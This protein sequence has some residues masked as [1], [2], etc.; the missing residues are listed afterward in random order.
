MQLN[1]TRGNGTGGVIVLARQGSSVDANPVNG[2]NYTFNANYGSG[3]EVGTGN[4]VVYKGAA[5]NAVITGLTPG[6]LYHFAVYEY[7]TTTYCHTLPGLVGNATTTGI[8]PSFCDTLSQFCCTPSLY[9][10]T[11]SGVYAGYLS[12]TNGY[13]FE[14]FAEYFA[15][16]EPFNQV[17][18]M[19]VYLGEV[20]TTTGTANVTFALWDNENGVPT[21]ILASKVVT[22]ANVKTAF[23]N[24]GYID[25]NFDDIIN[26]PANGFYLGLLEPGNA[27]AG[28]T[29]AIVTNAEDEGLNSGYTIYGSWSPYLDLFGNSFQHAIYAFT[30]FDNSLPPIAGFVGSPRRVALGSTVQFTDA[31]AGTDPT[32]WEWS[33]EGGT[34]ATSTEANQ[35]VTYNSLGFFDASLTVSN[36]NGSNS[37]TRT[38]YIEVF[39]PNGTTAFSL[40]FEACSD[41]QVDQFSPWTTLDV[42]GKVTYGSTNFDYPNEGYTGS[43]IAFNSANTT[44]AATGWEAHGGNL[45]GICMAATTPPNNDWLMSTQIELGEN[46]SF[47]FWAKSITATYGLERFIVYVST[48]GNATANFVKISAGTYLEAPTTWTQYTYDLSAYDNMSVYVAIRCVSNDA[49]AFMLDDIEIYSEYVAPVCD[50]TADNTTVVEGSTVNFTDLSTQMPT[51]WQWSFPGGTPSS[52]T[53]QNPAIVYSTPGTYNVS[54]TVTNSAGTDSEVKTGYITVTP[55]PTVIVLWNFPNT[56]D[57]NIADAGITNNLTKTIVPFGGVNDVLYTAAGVSTRSIDGETWDTGNGTKG[58]SVNFTTLG[59]GTLKLSFAQMSNHANS[60]RDFKVQYSLNGTSWTD[61]GVN[62]T[63]VEDVW[64]VRNDIALPAACENKA[65]VYLRWIMTSNT[66]C[67][68]STVNST[69]TTRRNA[70]D[71]IKVTG[72]P[73]ATPPV[74]DFIASSTQICAGQSVTFSDLS[75]NTPTS[76]AWTF[77]GGS[78]ATSNLQSPTVSYATAGT[79]QV[80]LTATNGSGSDTE[81]KVGYITVNA[82]PTVSASNTGPYCVGNTISLNATGSGGTSYSWT[83]PASFSSTAEDPTRTNALTTHTGNY[84]VVL[85]NTVTGCTATASTSVTVN[86]NPTISASNTGPYCAGQTISL[87]ATGSAG[88]TFAWSGPNSYSSTTEDPS[89]SNA[90]SINAGTYTVVY[91]NTTTNCFASANT[92]VVVNANPTVSPTNGGPYCAGQTIALTANGSGGTSYAWTGPNSYAN[93][94]ANPSIP[95]GQAVNAGTYTLVLTNTGTG[96]T[97]TGTTTVTVNPQPTISASNN[98]PICAGATL[99]LFATGSGGTAYS[100]TGP[101]SFSTII[102]DP[103]RTNAL[104]TYSGNYTVVLTNTTTGCTASATTSATVNANPTISASNNGPICAGATLNLFAAGSGGTGYSWTGPA[105][106]NTTIEDP[107]RTNALSTYS[108]TYTVVLTNSTT[109]CT[110]SATTNATINDNPTISASNNGPICADQHLTCLRQAQE[111]RVTAG[112]DP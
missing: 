76:W 59:Y 38:D 17:W 111:E 44:P 108:G 95:N 41:F 69:N 93:A 84:N 42:D 47:S 56:T 39:D 18:G 91:T 11:S 73:I 78:P 48:T 19:R 8:V 65:N 112:Q 86:S 40:D 14:G 61:L 24:L 66:G 71:D 89:I 52:S 43:F 80:S 26:A 67:G 15:E 82:N 36:A 58:W 96:C 102:E 16:H 104:T 57:N 81:T 35:V 2:V 100:W 55:T 29:I 33:F 6:T 90:Q 97:A 10:V 92:I 20:T 13:G 32:S 106:F 22:M 68:G 74:A 70:M 77:A 34:P 23:D 27:A 7:A 85:T 83:G 72:L 28:D 103:S 101:V 25:I 1:W 12:G 4:Y 109:G 31:S 62:I 5:S 21:N 99:N 46:S 53:V 37:V 45:C 107:S 98:G 54:L 49:Y 88:N 105:S 87:N 94:T 110:A 50:F 63:L 75:T 30:C 64:F 79:Y 9:T 3:M 60:P 51:V